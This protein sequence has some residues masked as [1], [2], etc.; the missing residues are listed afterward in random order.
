MC[1]ET[2][3]AGCRAGRADAGSSRVPDSV[4]GWVRAP[5]PKAADTDEVW[6]LGGVFVEVLPGACLLL[7]LLSSRHPGDTGICQKSL[8][9]HFLSSWDLFV[10][11]NHS[12]PGTLH[13]AWHI[14]GAYTYLLNE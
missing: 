4:P 1:S 6:E 12:V 3:R 7:D 11:L 10:F 9:F 8:S 2:S 13:E 14:I 5:C